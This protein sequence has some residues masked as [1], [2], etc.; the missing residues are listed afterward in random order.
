MMPAPVPS[1]ISQTLRSVLPGVKIRFSQ[2]EQDLYVLLE[3]PSLATCNPTIAVQ[4][5]QDCFR[6]CVVEGI[7][8]VRVF[9]RLLG[10][11]QVRWQDTFRLSS[12]VTP[13]TSKQPS[14]G[15]PPHLHPS[16]PAQATSSS[17]SSP[18]VS[19]GLPPHLQPRSHP[20][21]PPERTAPTLPPTVT[22]KVDP[23]PVAT[24]ASTAPPRSL[25]HPHF[26]AFTAPPTEM[27][28][29]LEPPPGCASSP[30]SGRSGGSSLSASAGPDAGWGSGYS[31]GGVESSPEY[32][33][34]GTPV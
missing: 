4:R 9:G 30:E 14:A 23:A 20:A 21:P 18:S 3:Y 29:V 12:R 16:V 24:P 25:N 6:T 13:P 17:S 5:I 7:D 19:F 27:A 8:Q 11:K 10:E 28:A 33:S 34:P 26:H 2:R 32:Q 22:P 31:G 15:I 1:H